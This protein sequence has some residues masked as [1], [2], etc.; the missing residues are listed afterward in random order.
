[1]VLPSGILTIGAT[2]DYLSWN[3][4][5]WQALHNLMQEPQISPNDIDGGF[6]F[7]GW[8]LYDYKYKKVLTKVGG[9]SIKMTT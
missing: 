5:R 3:R 6:E 9:G 1:M 7:N 4:V 8:Y 2:H